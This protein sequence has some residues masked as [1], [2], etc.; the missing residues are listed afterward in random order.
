MRAICSRRACRSGESAASDRK[1]RTSSDRCTSSPVTGPFDAPAAPAPDSVRPVSWD[2]AVPAG[3]GL[4]APKDDR[5]GSFTFITILS[6]AFAPN[7]NIGRNASLLKNRDA[8]DR[9]SK[10][11]ITLPSKA[12]VRNL[13]V[14]IVP[15]LCL[16]KKGTGLS[17]RYSIFSR[18]ECW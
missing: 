14:L 6:E 1:L 8:W 11:C 5:L 13:C 17:A 2:L 18:I 15:W 7:S 3:G 10:S 12:R 4:A 16:S 9:V